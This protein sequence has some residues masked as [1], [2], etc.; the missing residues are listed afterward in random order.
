MRGEGKG[1]E[2][3]G[4]IEAEGRKCKGMIGMGGKVDNR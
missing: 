1:C 3:T 4:V 2:G